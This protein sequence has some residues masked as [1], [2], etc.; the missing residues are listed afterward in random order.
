MKYAVLCVGHL[1][2]PFRTIKAGQG[3]QGRVQGRSKSTLEWP[4]FGFEAVQRLPNGSMTPDMDSKSFLNKGATHAWER[5]VRKFS[6]SRRQES[7]FP[8]APN[9][10]PNCP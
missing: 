4:E 2:K 8:N 10:P 1:Y 7:R 6:P 3:W 5:A 9:G